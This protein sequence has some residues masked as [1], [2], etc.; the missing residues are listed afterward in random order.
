MANYSLQKK[1][2][3]A[4][5][6]RLLFGAG[7]MLYVLSRFIPCGAVSDSPAVGDLDYSW[8]QA[9]QIGFAT[10]RQFGT[11]IIFTYG[12]WGFL[13]C[14]YY[15]PTYLISVMAWASLAL[16][17]LYA[18]WQLA[19]HFS[20]NR[21][22]AGLWLVGV[23]AA[24]S[25]PAK[26]DFS[27][28]PVAWVML[29]LCQHFFIEEPTLTPTQILLAASM[30]WLSLVKLTNLME[31]AI[32]LAVIAAD[33]IFRQRRFP[34]IVAVWVVSLLFF[35][36]AAGQHLDL[37]EP[38][39]LNSWRI[40]AGY[41]EAMMLSGETETC[42]AICYLLLAAL[43]CMLFGRMA[44]SR[45][46]YFA[47]LPTTALGMILFIVFKMGYVRNSWE[48]EAT[49]AMALV[50]V[51]L[52]C[53]AVAQKVQ[54]RLLGAAMCLLVFATLFAA[55]TFNYWL[56]GN[57]LGRQ[58]VQTFSLT[59]LFAPVAA[60]GTGSLRNEYE[61]SLASERKDSLLSSLKGGADLYAYDQ[62]FLFAHRLSYQPR[63]VM[64][65]YSAY[66]PELAEM[67]SAHLRTA[68]AADNILFAVQTID[69]RFPAL[70]DGL[71]WP[72]LLTRYDLKGVAD[73]EAK[74]L[75]L[76][77]TAAPRTF[78]LIP[79]EKVA[80]HM[81]EPVAVP[82]VIKGPVWVEI[83]IKKTLAG[84]LASIFYK[85]PA[86]ILDVTL[87]NNTKHH[88][89]LIPGMA[90]SGFLLSPI[91][92]DNAS[93][94][95]LATTGWR[96]D[97][98]GSEVKSI[99]VSANAQSGSTICYQSPMVMRFYCLDYSL[100]DSANIPEP[101]FKAKKWNYVAMPETSL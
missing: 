86:L 7:V 52:I 80:A 11:D 34:W 60:S 53:L 26:D 1:I 63:P 98:A 58:F 94:A 87:K 100:P 95:A 21:L 25:I 88:Y 33:N 91:I 101:V 39:L 8:T 81:G 24:V 27:I 2:D 18:G 65:S 12:P 85:P 77:R 83:V 20:G 28:I 97:L 14:G 46:R 70:D 56:P 19:C 78:H 67:N 54:K 31:C 49:S 55:S 42:A 90:A 23:T 41:T 36:V 45:H 9:L 50:L 59:S 48:H 57:G 73:A 89:R 93:F 22:V 71:S 17:F 76:T 30:G 40:T 99:T 43:L 38:F 96:Q 6:V 68:Q 16:V 37:L 64:Q 61:S 10:H 3:W 84:K 13:G 44:W 72:E 82:A 29:L 62:I 4:L 66:T 35:W 69:G 47:V 92:A 74:F 15:P 75:L 5:V 79:L 32:V 51:S